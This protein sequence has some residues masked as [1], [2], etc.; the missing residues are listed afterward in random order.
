MRVT[1]DIR[2]IENGAN[3]RNVGTRQLLE[4]VTRGVAAGLIGAH[5]EGDARRAV[6]DRKSV[7]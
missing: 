4:R 2:A 3:D 7:V 5:D 6:A 1:V